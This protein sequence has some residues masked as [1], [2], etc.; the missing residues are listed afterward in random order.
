MKSLNVPLIN[1]ESTELDTVLELYGTRFDVETVDWPEVSSYAPICSGRIAR[2][3]EALI[4]DFR[5][6]G[7]DLR[8]QNLADNGRQWE[9]SCVEVFIQDPNG[10]DY[11]NFE[12]NPV[13]KVLACSGSCREGRVRRPENQMKSILRFVQCE[14]D[15]ADC[16]VDKGG[17][18]SWR[19]AVV[20]PFWMIGVDYHNLPKT[21]KANFYKCGDKTAHPH[22]LSWN[23]IEIKIPDF[24]RPDFFGE[25]KLV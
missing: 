21:I 4:V 8:V 3:E 24:H 9:D 23:P 6:S 13:G 5:V 11:Y 14:V 20:I 12:I 17:L 15:P 2:T 7:L 22:F 16:P 19:V 10:K 18:H 1:F 25:L